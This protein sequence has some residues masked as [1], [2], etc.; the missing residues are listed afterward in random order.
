MAALRASDA[1]I[2]ES[3]CGVKISVRRQKNDQFGPGPTAHMVALPS[4]KEAC[5]ARVPPGWLRLRGW[6]H[7]RT[8][9]PESHTPLFVGLVRAR[10]GPGMAASGPSASREISFEGRVLSRRKGDA[11][12]YI[13]NGMT[14]EPTQESGGRKS[15]AVMEAVYD[16]TRA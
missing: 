16:K 14:R 12:L 4:W 3:A 9:D 1:R 2:S 10:F 6:L 7:S 11:R 8:T 15:S 5:P 13:M